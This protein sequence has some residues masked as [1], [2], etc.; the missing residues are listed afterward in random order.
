[1]FYSRFLV[2]IFVHAN[3]VCA[4]ANPIYCIFPNYS[5][6]VIQIKSDDYETKIIVGSRGTQYGFVRVGEVGALSLARR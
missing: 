2:I 4:V 3:E 5:Y 1:M 6:L